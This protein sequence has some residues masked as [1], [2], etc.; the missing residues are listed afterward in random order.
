MSLVYHVIAIFLLIK[1]S[2]IYSFIFGSAGS[3]LLPG[4]FSSC[5]D[6]SVLSSR[7]VQASHCRDFSCCRTLALGHSGF[8][9]VALQLQNTGS[10]AVVHRP[11]CSGA[12][13]IFR[14]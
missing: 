9:S 3:L 6:Q 13:E 4:L 5:S 12:C 11:S 7:N 14:D 10:K 8:S 1:K 2:F